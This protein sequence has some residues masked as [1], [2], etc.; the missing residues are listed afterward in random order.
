M[1][2]LISTT[3]CA[4]LCSP[5]HP[6]PCRRMRWQEWVASVCVSVTYVDGVEETNVSGTETS[7]NQQF[8][9][10][11]SQ[12][13]LRFQGQKMDTWRLPYLPGCRLAQN[14]DLP[15]FAR[16]QLVPGGG[17]GAG[18]LND[19]PIRWGQAKKSTRNSS[20]FTADTSTY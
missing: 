18:S 5:V 15:V 17:G 19:D 3:T 20:F 16:S 6:I 8:A 7:R 2:S 4:P 11:K 1:S 13:L 12:L 9:H 14:Q 10:P